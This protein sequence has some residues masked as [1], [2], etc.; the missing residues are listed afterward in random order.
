MKKTATILLFI[1]VFIGIISSCNQ[2]SASDTTTGNKAEM[3]Q[4]YALI[5]TYC[6]SCQLYL[7]SR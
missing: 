6:V 7:T 3:E 2:N 4:G 5:N 1:S